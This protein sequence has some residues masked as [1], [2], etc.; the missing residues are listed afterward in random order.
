VQSSPCETNTT[1]ESVKEE[2][3]LHISDLKS[4]NILLSVDIKPPIGAKKVIYDVNTGV[5]Y[6]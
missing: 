2:R 3:P 1:V 4:E 5:S 6:Q